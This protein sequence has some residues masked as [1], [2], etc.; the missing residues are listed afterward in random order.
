MAYTQKFGRPSLGGNGEPF[1]EKGLI[2]PTDPKPNG[3]VASSDDL[4]FGGGVRNELPTVTLGTVKSTKP[5]AKKPSNREKSETLRKQIIAGTGDLLDASYLPNN[6]NI[7]QTTANVTKNTASGKPYTVTQ[8]T[9]QNTKGGT[10]TVVESTP[11]NISLGGLKTQYYSSPEAQ[12]QVANSINRQNTSPT[13][14]GTSTASGRG[15]QNYMTRVTGGGDTGLPL[16]K[17]AQNVLTGDILGRISSTGPSSNG[18]FRAAQTGFYAGNR[19]SSN[20]PQL[21][22]DKRYINVTRNMSPKD[23]QSFVKQ[24][25]LSALNSRRSTAAFV[26]G[27][28][29][30]NQTFMSN[31]NNSGYNVTSGKKD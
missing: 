18:G 4:T 3:V 28:N 20:T 31:S 10:P 15:R 7:K 5:V 17:E 30:K 13:I 29:F 24:D 8:D 9:F 11:S 26:K 6:P 1:I 21:D 2:T 16:V 12:T 14:P 23:L 25:S 27:M 22:G 19:T